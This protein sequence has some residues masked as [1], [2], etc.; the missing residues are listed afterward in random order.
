MKHPI[1]IVHAEPVGL[2]GV[3]SVSFVQIEP[4]IVELRVLATRGIIFEK[5][6]LLDSYSNKP[7]DLI[8][9]GDLGTGVLRVGLDKIHHG[10]FRVFF[11]V[12]IWH[13][14]TDEFGTSVVMVGLDMDD[15]AGESH[16]LWKAS[17]SDVPPVSS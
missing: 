14:P 13:A 4:H 5:I 10:I 9:R 2:L 11:G 8:E 3:T 15:L 7:F 6:T 1:T 16:F 12:P 17:S